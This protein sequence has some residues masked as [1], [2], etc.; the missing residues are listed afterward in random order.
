VLAEQQK[1]WKAYV[2][3]VNDVMGLSGA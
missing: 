1:N 3:A 2:A